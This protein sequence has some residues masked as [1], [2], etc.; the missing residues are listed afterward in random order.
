MSNILNPLNTQRLSHTLLATVALNERVRLFLREEKVRRALSERDI[1]GMLNWSHSKLASKM[2][3]RTDITLDELDALCFALG[4]QP[5]EAVRDRGLEFCAEMTPTELRLLEQI[6]RLPKPTYDVLL[7]FLRSQQSA[8]VEKRG[9]TPRRS[10][11]P[12]SHSG[13]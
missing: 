9:A 11:V 12:K 2:N 6:R 4:V 5:T 13:R 1:A 10:S 3:G 8:E 7:H